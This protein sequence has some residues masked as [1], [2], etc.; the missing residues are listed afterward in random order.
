MQQRGRTQLSAAPQ[1][2][3]SSPRRL[4]VRC[5]GAS[6]EWIDMAEMK[7]ASQARSLVGI[8]QDNIAYYFG[9]PVE[10][11][12]VYD[13]EGLLR[14][15][16]DFCR[17]F[18]RARPSIEVLDARE[19]APEQLEELTRNLSDVNLKLQQALEEKDHLLASLGMGQE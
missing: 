19:L 3:Q 9:I 8:L 17:A 14:T 1:A 12:A 5:G 2:L 7:D 11:Q 4:Q 13:E 18:H 6:Y 10:F 15:V 16:A